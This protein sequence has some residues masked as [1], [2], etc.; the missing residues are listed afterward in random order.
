MQI[1]MTYG[2]RRHH[3][4]EMHDMDVSALAAYTTPYPTRSTSRS[5]LR[6]GS[7]KTIGLYNKQEKSL[8]PWSG[9]RWPATSS[10]RVCSRD[11]AVCQHRA[12]LCPLGIPIHAV[13]QTV[14][15]CYPQG[16]LVRHRIR[17]NAKLSLQQ[18]S[19][20]FQTAPAL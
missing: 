7:S 16:E 8:N 2:T 13:N 4:I 9:N 11:L 20:Y 15:R 10:S 17:T 3:F 5:P 1:Y 12:V 19:D 14:L 6:A 18:T